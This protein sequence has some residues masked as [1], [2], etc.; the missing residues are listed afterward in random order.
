MTL[1]LLDGRPIPRTDL[2]RRLAAL[3]GGPR[4]TALPQPGSPEDRQLTRWVAQVLLTEALCEAVA[5]ER[6]LPVD[7]EAPVRLDQQVAVEL[8][9]ITAAAYEG[10]AAVRAVYEWVTADVEPSKA[11]RAHNRTMTARPPSVVWHLAFPDGK[12]EAAPESLPLT[13][14]EA[15]RKAPRGEEVTVGLWTATLL[16]ERTTTHEGT[17]IDEASRRVAF[18]RWLDA[19]RA[20]RLTL[21]EGLEHPGDPAQPDNHHRH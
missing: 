10:S 6:N 20:A 14:A 5:A 1:G 18:T 16:F 7:A 17:T 9:S 4:S 13:L 11:E 21:V 3:R 15:L 12:C 2:D 8:G 19:E